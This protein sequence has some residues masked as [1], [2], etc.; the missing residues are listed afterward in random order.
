MCGNTKLVIIPTL[1]T[2]CVC[3]NSLIEV[4]LT[5]GGGFNHDVAIFWLCK[6]GIVSLK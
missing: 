6:M 2:L 1:P 5:G 4:C 3:E